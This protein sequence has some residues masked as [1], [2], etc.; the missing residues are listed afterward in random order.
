MLD[1]V[2]RPVLGS[3]GVD[4]QD[5][6]VANQSRRQTP[7]TAEQEDAREQRLLRSLAASPLSV[8]TVRTSDADAGAGADG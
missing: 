4:Y 1:L 5:S 7:R 2:L 8:R 6:K 3:M